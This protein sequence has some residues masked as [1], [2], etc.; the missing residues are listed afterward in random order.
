[1]EMIEPADYHNIAKVTTGQLDTDPKLSPDESLVA[2]PVKHTISD[3]EY[4][5]TIHVM[6]IDGTDSRRYTTPG[7]VATDPSWSPDGTELAFL[8]DRG[9]PS[10]TTQVWV[11]PVDGGEARQVTR[12]VGGVGD[13][14][15]RPDGEAIVFEQTV[16]QSERDRGLDL[17]VAP[18]EEYERQPPDPRVITRSAYR[19]HDSFIDG[20]RSHIYTLDIDTGAVSRV[21]TGDFDYLSPEWGDSETLYYTS[22]Q[23][24]DPDDNYIQTLFAYDVASETE[25]Q[26]TQFTFPASFPTSPGLAA[27]NDGR[28]A[29]PF[30]PAERATMQQTEIHVFDRDTGEITVLTEDFDR[31]VRRLSKK[32][33]WGPDRRNL[34]FT[35]PG[36]GRIQIWRVSA[37]G[38]SKPEPV[39]D[40][41]VH[42]VTG[43]DVGND[44]IVFAQ[45]EWNHPGD[46][47][48]Y[49]TDSSCISRLTEVNDE[50]LTEREVGRP[51]EIHFESGDGTPVQ[52][53]V[54][55]PRGFDPD[56]QYPLAVE[57]HGGPHYLWT[58]SGTMWHEFQSLA[59]AGYVVFWCNPRGS[60]GW[61][62]EFMQ[63]IYQN[64]GGPDFDDIMAGVDYVV[65]EDYIDEANQFVIGGSYGGFMTS[66]AIGQTD[67]FKAAV[68]QRSVNDIIGMYGSTDGYKFL[69][70]EFGTV[71]WEDHD[72]LWEHSPVANV[73]QVST[74][75]MIMHAE[76][77]YRAS[78]NT[79]EHFYRGLKKNDVTACFVRYPR[80]GH[81]LSRAGEPQHVIDRLERII[82]WLNGFSDHH[83]QEPVSEVGFGLDSEGR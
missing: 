49:S 67:R 38:A 19:V 16:T 45:G 54:L 75:T 12:V 42:H 62:E 60:V 27:T 2:Y 37:D 46:I 68:T 22:K 59:A 6:S 43:F 5:V 30:R 74:P 58:T 63:A 61:G 44:H 65:A 64:W 14:A 17:G 71:P 28:I 18:D 41:E 7:E 1:M 9:T 10:E 48:R 69:E 24:G 56:E 78:I 34:Y 51:E 66:W 31:M 29:Y 55:R 36:P 72:L 73:D 80:E 4:E 23:T 26:L 57:I 25:E 47:F 13:Y 11:L 70:D 50:Y 33:K 39:L 3:T 35:T 15:W 20:K 77:D 21:T 52:G 83:D 8:S 79:A 53:F 81:E 40:D 76:E 32:P 82:R